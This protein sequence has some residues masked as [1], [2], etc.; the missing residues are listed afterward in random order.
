M[1][2][3]DEITNFNEGDQEKEDPNNEDETFLLVKLL[4]LNYR[5]IEKNV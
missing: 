3:G 2:N 1:D 5:V 4:E